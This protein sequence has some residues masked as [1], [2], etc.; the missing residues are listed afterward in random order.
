MS[1]L[2]RIFPSRRTVPE[3]PP[4]G[5]A[6]ACPPALAQIAKGD[7]RV[8]IPLTD[9]GHAS[10]GLNGRPTRY[11]HGDHGPVQRFPQAIE[12]GELVGNTAGKRRSADGYRR[13]PDST[14]GADGNAPP[15]APQ[16]IG[17]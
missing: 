13:L 17:G 9:Q 10:A 15:P 7:V 12:L 2:A 3:L 8:A 4:A 11:T 5:W 16:R 1:L 6:G 14:V